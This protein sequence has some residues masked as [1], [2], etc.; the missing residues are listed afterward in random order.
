MIFNSLNV[1]SAAYVLLDVLHS[2]E[3]CPLSQDHTREVNWLSLSR[4]LS[5]VIAPWP[6][7]RLLT[8]LAFPCCHF[9]WLALSLVLCMLL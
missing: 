8:D 6:E 1:V 5:P 9:A 2:L 3:P 4:Q 7:A